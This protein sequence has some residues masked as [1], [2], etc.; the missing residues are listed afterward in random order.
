MLVEGA[1]LLSLVALLSVTNKASSSNGHGK[2][3]WPVP[4]EAKK[5]KNPI[6]LTADGLSSARNIYHEKCLRCH[7]ETG[8]GDGA[9]AGMYSTKAADFTDARMMSEMSDGEVFYKIT[10]GR[11][12]MPS[13]KKSL[14]E[15]QRWQ[16]VHLL[17]KFP[18]KP[19][20]S[21]DKSN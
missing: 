5:R 20:S 13:F 3:D 10:E 7:G 2:E 14:S 9:E 8:K 12:P 18:E 6:T 15:E 16:L 19:A 17:R 21:R 4:D 11:R 1:A